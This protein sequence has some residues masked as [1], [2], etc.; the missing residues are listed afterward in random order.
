MTAPPRRRKTLAAREAQL[1]Y[2]MLLPT[3]L[4]VFAIV[5]FP[6]LAN[7]WI[8]FKSGRS[9]RPARARTDHQRER[10]RGT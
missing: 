3:F 10:P 5:L 6:V 4:I 2:W 9:S 7:F 8:S 1:A